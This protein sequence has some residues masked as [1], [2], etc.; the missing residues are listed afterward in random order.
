MSVAWVTK[1][2]PSSPTSSPVQAG[3][4]VASINQDVDAA[5]SRS[6]SSADAKRVPHLRQILNAFPLISEPRRTDARTLVANSRS[7][8]ICVTLQGD[9]PRWLKFDGRNRQW[10]RPAVIAQIPSG[11]SVLSDRRLRGAGPV[12]SASQCNSGRPY[13]MLSRHRLRIRRSAGTGPTGRSPP[14]PASSRTDRP[15]KWTPPSHSL[16]HEGR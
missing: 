8:V 7:A 2:T 14:M 5:R 1:A 10:L 6:P 11:L 12:T 4:I 9:R 16:G 13:R 3:R 15:V